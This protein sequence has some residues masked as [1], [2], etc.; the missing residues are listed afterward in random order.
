LRTGYE[1]ARLNARVDIGS[2]L[3][4]SAKGNASSVSTRFIYD[5]QD[6]AVVPNRGVRMSSELRWYFNSPGASGS[7]TQAV[8]E[9]SVFKSIREHSIIFSFGG[10]GTTFRGSPGPVQQFTLGGLRRLSAFG[11][12]ELRGDDFAYGGAGYLYRAG[13]A[14]SLFVKRIYFGGWLE[15]GS[16]FFRTGDA[17]FDYDGAGAFIVQTPLGPMTLGGALGEGGH[18]KA[19]FSFGR[20]F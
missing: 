2:H 9:A 20:S 18:R 5:G 4:P 12:G 10:G 7:F 3:L 15:G 1:L 17:N 13:S 16:A 19:F 14:S 6:S 11:R 8:V